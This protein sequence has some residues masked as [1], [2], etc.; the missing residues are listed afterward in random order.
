[1]T[2]FNPD[3]YDWEKLKGKDKAFIE[4][5]NAAISDLDVAFEFHLNDRNADC[6]NLSAV[7]QLIKEIVSDAQVSVTRD[8]LS[9]RTEYVASFMDGNKEYDEN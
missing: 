6:E 3:V 8:L 5:Y 4:G 2:Y 1:M 7:K 9:K